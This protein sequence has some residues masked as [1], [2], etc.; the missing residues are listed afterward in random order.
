[1]QIRR[2]D[3]DVSNRIQT[4]DPA[5]VKREVCRLFHLLY[6][7]TLPS[8]IDRAFADVTS[9]YEGTYPSYR[10]CDTDY[11]NLQHV[12]DVTLAMARLM[13]GYERGRHDAETLGATRF[14]LGVVC[15]LF[16]DMGYVRKMDDTQTPNGAVYTRTHVS[17][18]ATFLRDYL[19]TAGLGEFAHVGA[20]LIHYTGFEKR[21]ADIHIAD[22]M[23]RLLGSLL[24]SADIIAQM[25]D[26]C[27]LEK[28]RDRL[29]PEFVA[30]GIDVGDKGGATEVL[31]ASGA[32][33]V[34]QTPTFFAGAVHRLEHELG[35]THNY[36]AM[37]FGGAHLY[38]HAAT[39]NVH[40]AKEMSEGGVDTL[41]RAPPVAE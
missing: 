9:L 34:R 11:H 30:A 32:D 2:N 38:L 13:D 39:R 8:V 23:L 27:Y 18:G 1:M 40:F 36:A 41:R 17:R 10:A 29:Y 3:F 5:A 7:G 20:E 6:A 19:P 25:S 33:L 35:G 31:F 15:A 16:H 37:H 22:P 26:R 12:L 21:I 24:G 28:C 4:T 14:Q